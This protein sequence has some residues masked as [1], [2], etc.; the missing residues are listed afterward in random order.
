LVEEFSDLG[1]DLYSDLLG[2]QSRKYWSALMQKVAHEKRLDWESEGYWKDFLS[3]VKEV[4]DSSNSN[5]E[6][7]SKLAIR[8]HFTRE[9]DRDAYR[10]L[11]QIVKYMYQGEVNPDEPVERTHRRIERHQQYAGVLLKCD[12]DILLLHRSHHVDAPGTWS[13]PAGKLNADEDAWLGATRE[14]YEETRIDLRGRHPETKF[15]DR[16][17]DHGVSSTFTTFLVEIEPDQKHTISPRLN[18]EHTEWRW[19]DLDDLS[20]YEIHFGLRRSLRGLRLI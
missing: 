9:R 1:E 18:W 16:R 19:V 11:R 2:I 15:E 3:E 5:T 13:I 6:A 4:I 8:Y 14:M 10:D 20:Q 7:V 12:H 17:G